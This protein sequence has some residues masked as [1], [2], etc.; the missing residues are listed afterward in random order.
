[1]QKRNQ[2]LYY[3]ISRKCITQNIAKT[4]LHNIFIFIYLAQQASK[5]QKSLRIPL[6]LVSSDMDM[7]ISS[8]T[9]FIQTY[10][11]LYEMRIYVWTL[12]TNAIENSF[13]CALLR[14]DICGAF[15]LVWVHIS[16]RMSVF[17]FYP[18]HLH[19]LEQKYIWPIYWTILFMAVFGLII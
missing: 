13:G 8:A 2:S 9:L 16:I 17:I 5:F 3:S 4:K 14:T 1:M 6:V 7:I 12:P 15:F 18:L 11:G 19:K 10:I